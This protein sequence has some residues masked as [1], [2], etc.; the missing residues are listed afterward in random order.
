MVGHSFFSL[1]S[2][3]K[4]LFAFP[5]LFKASIPFLYKFFVRNSFRDAQQD[6]KG[7]LLYPL[8]LLYFFSLYL[9]D[10]ITEG[11]CANLRMA[12]PSRINILP[13]RNSRYISRIGTLQLTEE[14]AEKERKDMRAKRHEIEMLNDSA[15]ANLSVIIKK[16]GVTQEVNCLTWAL[17]ALSE[18]GLSFP[19]MTFIETP[20][21]APN[22]Y[23]Q[24]LA[25]N[26][27]AVKFKSD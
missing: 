26:P 13:P 16:F 2:L 22:S 17:G 6:A 11:F 23:I 1:R 4:L 21:A 9:G 18:A 15:F 12:L 19:E 20:I 24:W 5:F 14:K 25:L 3:V 7:K 8:W 10:R 27:S